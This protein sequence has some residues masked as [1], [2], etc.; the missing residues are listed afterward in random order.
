MVLDFRRV[1]LNGLGEADDDYKPLGTVPPTPP[2]C[3]FLELY[4]SNN[5][6]I[7]LLLSSATGVLDSLLKLVK[8]NSLL[9]PPAGLVFE[10]LSVTGD[11]V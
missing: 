2:I 7:F 8:L 3:W 1:P 11:T 4:E 6:S 5:P 9:K 10:N